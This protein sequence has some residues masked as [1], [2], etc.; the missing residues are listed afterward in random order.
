MISRVEI[1]TIW[2][3]V[4]APLCTTPA[5]L[6]LV[7]R[8]EKTLREFAAHYSATIRNIDVDAYV[9]TILEAMPNGMVDT[10]Y[11]YLLIETV[12]KEYGQE[13]RTTH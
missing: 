1:E 12:R 10:I 3:T 6:E 5:G 4:V 7:E 2:R 9:A 8:L 13:H 11:P